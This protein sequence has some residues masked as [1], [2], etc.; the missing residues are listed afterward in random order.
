MSFLRGINTSGFGER[1]GPESP[2]QEERRRA[3]RTS[4]LGV[5]TLACARCDAPVSTGG[6]TLAADDAMSCPYCRHAGV[7]RD[8][9]SLRAPSR[10]ARVVIRVVIRAAASAAPRP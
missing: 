8:F 6:Q 5:G 2:A 10:P 7:V 3:N 4:V 9:L 1:G